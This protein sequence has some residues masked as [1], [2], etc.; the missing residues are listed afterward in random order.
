M[1]RTRDVAVILTER[2]RDVLEHHREHSCERQQTFYAELKKPR[3]MEHDTQ[4]YRAYL[5]EAERLQERGAR[6]ERVILD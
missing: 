6:I 3:E 1:D 2:G 4:V 5:R